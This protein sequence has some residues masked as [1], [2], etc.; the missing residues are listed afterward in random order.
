MLW[1]IHRWDWVIYL[2][3][4]LSEIKPVFV[5]YSG[6]QL[7]QISAEHIS[8]YTLLWQSYSNEELLYWCCGV[9]RVWLWVPLLMVFSRLVWWGESSSQSLFSL[10]DVQRLQGPALFCKWSD[11]F[12]TK[13]YEINI[14]YVIESAAYGFYSRVVCVK[15]PNERGTSEWGRAFDTNNE[16]IK[17]H[18][19]HFLCRELFITQNKGIFIELALWTQIRN[20][21]SL[22]IE[23]NANLI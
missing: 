23:P 7:S 19:K 18:T 12:T 17:P 15:N 13:P 2:Y 6:Q 3:P 22:T 10:P 4:Y 8:S 14:V 9:S 1:P 20:K 5:F 21:N 16:W 11:F